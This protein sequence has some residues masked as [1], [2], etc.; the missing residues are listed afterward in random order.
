MAAIVTSNC[1]KCRFMD[2]VAVCPVECFHADDDMLYI[3]PDECVDCGAC[4]PECPVEAIYDEVDLPP[5]LAEWATI[6]AT[7]SKSLP[8]I[9]IREP[10][11]PTAVARKRELGF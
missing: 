3:D 1:V 5:A 11:L 7:R 4:L 8:L 10:A 6:N 2:C 9:V